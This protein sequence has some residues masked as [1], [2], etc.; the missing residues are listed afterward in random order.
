MMGNLKVENVSDNVIAIERAV[1]ER[2][3]QT[4]ILDNG[5]EGTFFRR[6]AELTNPDGVRVRRS[7]YLSMLPSDL[8]VNDIIAINKNCDVKEGARNREVKNA[9]GASLKDH[10]EGRRYHITEFGAGTAPILPYLPGGHDVTYHG[11]DCDPAI[12]N[13]LAAQGVSAS[14]WEGATGK[15]P[16]ADR[17]RIGVG[18]YSLHFMVNQDLPGHIRSLTSDDGFYVGNFYVDQREQESGGQRRKLADILKSQ[19]M[20]YVVLQNPANPTTEYWV[21]SPTAEK[22]AVDEFAA[23]LRSHDNGRPNGKPAPKRAAP[24]PA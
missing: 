16:P 6:G 15:A 14:T 21:I 12:V 17:T 10:F 19:N 8:S 7:Y 24:E 11:I 2:A 9:L 22:S 1:A 18:V 5:A 4:L 23:V 20:H 3:D 13:E